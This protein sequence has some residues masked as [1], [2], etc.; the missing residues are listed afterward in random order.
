MV[1]R[2]GN[3][4][5]SAYSGLSPATWWLSLVMLVN[6]A[7][8][9]VIPFMTLYLTEAK[10]YPIGKAGIVMAL[11]GAGAVCGGFLGGRLT[12][13]LGFY[14]IQLSALTFG[15]ILFILLG[16]MDSFP[17]IC[18]CTFLLATVNDSFRPANATAIAQYSKEENRTRSYSLNRLSINLGWAV[19]GALGGFI[20]SRNY[21]LL[22]WIDGLTNIGAAFL[23]RSVLSPSKNS[24]TP[25]HK[26]K[27]VPEKTRSA[28]SDTKYL[29]F[30]LLTVLFGFCFFQLFA[31][32]PV[33][34]KQRLHL[35]PSFIGIVMAFNGLLI[36]LF[37]MA[38]VFKLEQRKKDMQ[39]I[40]F[41][42]LLVG[43]SFII[44]NIVPG[45]ASLALLSTVIVTAGEML[46]MPF[47]NSFWISRTDH[48]NRGQY[49]GLY[50]AAWSIAQVLGPLIGSQIAQH[51]DF[52]ALW[53]VIGG[54]SIIAAAGFRWLQGME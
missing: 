24:Q 38:V 5:K 51:Y 25:S 49:A 50:T 35:S 43:F 33:F 3:L 28:F 8:T 42:T 1:K 21:H 4:Y 41:G 48:N 36:A 12:D 46:A 29:V 10:H 17:A 47:M 40:I 53:W 44:F 54:M 19:G 30:I 13:K 16:Q 6:R 9:M 27:A 2:I 45:A 23:L 37:E 26:D 22:F 18:V 14:N 20:A 15:G 52:V 7:G 39:H 32:I 11:F 34:F 31:T